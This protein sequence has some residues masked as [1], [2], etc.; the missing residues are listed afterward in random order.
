MPAGGSISGGNWR[1]SRTTGAVAL[2]G[3]GTIKGPADAR[4]IALTATGNGLGIGQAVAGH[5]QLGH[6]FALGGVTGHGGGRQQREGGKGEE[7]FCKRHVFSPL[8]L[9]VGCA[10]GVA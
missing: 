7:G 3:K 1:I 8:S 5:A 2:S 10:N 9:S 4:E 6:L